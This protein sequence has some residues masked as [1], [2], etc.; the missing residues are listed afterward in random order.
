MR[1][2]GRIQLHFHAGIMT[3]DG[4]SRDRRSTAEYSWVNPIQ[5][6]APETVDFVKGEIRFK[7]YAV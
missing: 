1:A 7:A 3:G 2:D 4:K 6:W 5:L